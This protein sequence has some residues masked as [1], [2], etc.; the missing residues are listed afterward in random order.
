LVAAW[1]DI[2]TKTIAHGWNELWKLVDI[3][4][5][6]APGSSSSAV[7]PSIAEAKSVG[8]HA[9]STSTRAAN[10]PRAITKEEHKYKKGLKKAG[11]AH[12][13]DPFAFPG[14]TPYVIPESREP[15]LKRPRTM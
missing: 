11:H 4:P 15:P 6:A 5:S 10:Y 1:A 9:D 12:G 8:A 3:T 2:T 14:T 13:V 7:H